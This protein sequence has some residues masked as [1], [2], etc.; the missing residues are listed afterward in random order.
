VLMW[1]PATRMQGGVCPDAGAQ[2]V[3]FSSAG[4]THE[5]IVYPWQGQGYATRRL[6]E[7]IVTLPVGH[8]GIFKSWIYIATP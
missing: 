4:S 8:A 1:E 7:V 2:Q 5:P 6:R 3:A